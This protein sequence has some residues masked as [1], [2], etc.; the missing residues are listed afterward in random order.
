MLVNF[1][2]S[3]V[4]HFDPSEPTIFCFA[5]PNHP[6]N[7]HINAAPRQRR[8]DASSVGNPPAESS[9][10]GECET[11]H[12]LR[13]ISGR[14]PREGEHDENS[15]FH[16]RWTLLEKSSGS[17]GDDPFEV[18]ETGQ[19]KWNEHLCSSI[20][21]E[22][23]VTFDIYISLLISSLTDYEHSLLFNCVVCHVNTIII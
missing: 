20:I 8:K 1:W 5:G 6:G 21:E 18:L 23:S 9:D 7:T 10:C 13:F 17:P 2:T 12:V 11:T 19:C 3:L 15:F 22:A 16:Q 4:S 14:E